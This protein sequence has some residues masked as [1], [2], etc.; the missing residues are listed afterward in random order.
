MSKPPHALPIALDRPL[1][2]FDIESTGINP[3]LD[4]IIELAIV[5]LMPDRSR[6]AHLY[7]MNPGVAIPPTATAVHGIS[8][9][10]VAACPRFA[11]VADTV[12]GVLE[13]CDLGGFNIVRF[14][15]PL[16]V[17]ECVRAGRKFVLDGRRIVDAQRIFH[18]REPRD[19][20]AAL[21]FYCHELHLGAHGAVADTDATVRVLE[22]QFQRYADLPRDMN[23]LHDYCNPRDPT[24]V[25]QGGKLKWEQGEIVL[26]FG[27]RRGQ[28]LRRIVE[29]EPTFAKWILRSDFAT[30]VKTVVENG[31]KGQ[32][33]TPPPPPAG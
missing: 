11:E 18:Q 27:M 4:R 9:A 13:G 25:D 30:D 32:W 8:D 16:L 5:K 23:T 6:Q 2:V 17:E 33:P 19:L 21:A 28:S 31:L 7:R 22:G 1:A 29:Q 20:T 15:V 12:L 3:R 26:N 24:W 10:D 14:D